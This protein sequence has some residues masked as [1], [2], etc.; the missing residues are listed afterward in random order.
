MLRLTFTT[1][2][3]HQNLKTRN[4][5]LGQHLHVKVSDFGLCR[6]KEIERADTAGVA[7]L[8]AAPEM[9]TF[10]SNYGKPVDVFSFGTFRITYFAKGSYIN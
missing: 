2:F 5:L 3:I 8:W 4:L 10:Q 1:G 6:I 9:L 7:Y